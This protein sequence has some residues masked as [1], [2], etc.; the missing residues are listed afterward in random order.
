MDEIIRAFRSAI[1]ERTR[2]ISISHTVFITG[3]IAPVK[4][5]SEMAHERG[6]LLLTDSAH[7]IGHLDLNMRDLGV[8]FFATSPYK[9]LGAP[10]GLGVLY[11][12]SDVQD[13]VW[14]TI[15]SSGWLPRPLPGRLSNP[16]IG[17]SLAAPRGSDSTICEARG[18]STFSVSNLMSLSRDNAS[19]SRAA[20]AILPSA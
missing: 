10:T 3:L 6:I 5:L 7:G 2:V 9:W 4:E 18:L 13:R 8:D 17:E 12:K 11:V 14:P 16:P 15:A 1:T 20:V 19:L